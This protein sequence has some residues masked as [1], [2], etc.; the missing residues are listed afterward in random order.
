MADNF[1]IQIN[2]ITALTVNYIYLKINILKYRNQLLIPAI[3]VG[4]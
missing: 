3:T 4:G 2:K 1:N